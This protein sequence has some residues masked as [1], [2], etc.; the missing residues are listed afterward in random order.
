[1]SVVHVGP[2]GSDTNDGTAAGNAKRTLRAA[3]EAVT[4]TGGLVQVGLGEVDLGGPVTLPANVHLAGL[5]RTVSAIR[6]PTDL[7]AGVPAIRCSA[8][9][10]MGPTIRDLSL[11]GP[12]RGKEGIIGQSPAAMD[13]ILLCSKASLQRVVVQF[14]RS[15]LVIRENHETLTDVKSVNNY[16]NVFFAP[17]PL[18]RGNQRF[19]GCDFSSASF[20]SVGIAPTNGID[21]GTFLAT[22][23]GRAP[24]GLYKEPTSAS[25]PVMMTSSAFINTTFESIGNAALYDASP[26]N[27]LSVYWCRFA[28]M[29]LSRWPGVAH[30]DFPTDADVALN[31]AMQLRVEGPGKFTTYR[32]TGNLG[33]TY[34]EDSNP[35][36]T[37]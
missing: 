17:N 31:G 23:L 1:M 30:P 33:V 22:D 26:S 7:G 3:V 27:S 6:C 2:G 35:P 14:F 29:G 32:R 19:F 4:G 20:A 36:V 34:Y 13:G 28:G 8:R 9:H 21:Y 5:D 15:G 16:Y 37:A 10:G 18:N 12:G 24:F 11:V 25:G